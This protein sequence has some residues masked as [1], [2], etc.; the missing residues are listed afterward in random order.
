MRGKVQL[1]ADQ[2]KYLTDFISKGKHSARSIR[3]ARTLLMLDGGNMTQ[4]QVAELLGCDTNTVNNT[5]KRYKETNRNIEQTLLEK[6]RPGQPS[7][8]SP[9]VEAHITVLAC[10]Q[11]VPDGKSEWTLRLMADKM[12]ELG[13]IDSISHETV[14]KVLKKASSNPGNRSSGAS[15]R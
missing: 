11:E 4:K 12:V 9:E 13:Y 2:R 6:P 14:R 8:V 3:R 7:K 5:V 15:A 1:E 10:S